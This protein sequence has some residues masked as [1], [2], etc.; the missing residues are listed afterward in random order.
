MTAINRR[1]IL[2]GAAMIPAAT[3]TPAPAAADSPW[4][5]IA[6]AP[7]D[8]TRVLLFLPP[9]SESSEG[10]HL[11][12]FWFGQHFCNGEL[13]YETRRWVIRNLSRAIEP[14]HWM[15]LPPTPI[16]HEIEPKYLHPARARNRN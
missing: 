4:R 3:A 14:T 5:P 6:T 8:G 10:I 9:C 2:A 11:G 16:G 15:P 12:W 13:E 7:L 1:N